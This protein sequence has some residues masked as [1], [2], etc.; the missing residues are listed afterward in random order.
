[1]FTCSTLGW[2]HSDLVNWT[3]VSFCYHE[4]LY[5]NRFSARTLRSLSFTVSLANGRLVGWGYCFRFIPTQRSM[6]ISKCY[7]KGCAESA[8]SPA[9]SG[10]GLRRRHRSAMSPAA[11]HSLASDDSPSQELHLSEEFVG[12]P[13]SRHKSSVDD[14]RAAVDTDNPLAHSSGEKARPLPLCSLNDRMEITLLPDSHE[15]RHSLVCACYCSGW[16]KIHVR[17]P[18]GD[19]CWITRILNPPQ[20]IADVFLLSDCSDEQAPNLAAGLSPH[21][22]GAAD[23]GTAHPRLDRSLSVTG[24]LTSNLHRPDVSL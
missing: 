9:S 21:L 1:M 8:R 4:R 18:T 5:S 24:V 11:A 6:R 3:Q 19:T 22:Q 10:C 20:N 16:A 2:I 13:R 15:K 23:T 7:F 14:R 12:R 17:R